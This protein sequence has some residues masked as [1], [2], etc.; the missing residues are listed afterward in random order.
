[1]VEYSKEVTD[2]LCTFQ[3]YIIPEC[4]PHNLHTLS[5]CTTVPVII[6]NSDFNS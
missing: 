3:Q 1:M 6:L 4:F 2:F 5:L